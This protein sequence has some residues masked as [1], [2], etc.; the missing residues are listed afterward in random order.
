MENI[1]HSIVVENKSRINITSVSEVTAFSDKEI[2]LK[3]KDNTVLFIF[4]SALKISC[5]DNKNGTFTALGSI[6][7]IRYKDAQD[8][9][10]KKVFK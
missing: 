3:L 1:V 2:K 10:I 4:G 7:N 5:F 6:E 9:L 8:N